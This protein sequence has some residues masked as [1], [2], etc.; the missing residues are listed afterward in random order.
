MDIENTNVLRMDVIKVDR[1]KK[2]LC[3]CF[4][5]KYTIDT[6][7]RLIYCDNCGAVV[8]PYDALLKFA[9]WGERAAKQSEECINQLKFL[10]TEVSELRNKRQQLSVYK[11]MASHYKQSLYPICY[12][13]KKAINPL[14]V[15]QYVSSKYFEIE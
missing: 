10:Q 9:E 2:K 8:D 14:K 13:C 11:D 5:T 7:N 15:T 3:N 1:A 12:H 4:C 6:E